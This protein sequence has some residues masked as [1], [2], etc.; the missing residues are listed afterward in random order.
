MRRNGLRSSCSGTLIASSMTKLC[1]RLWFAE[2]A[3]KFMRQLVVEYYPNETGGML[4]GYQAENG[5]IVITSVIGPGPKGIHKPY[6]FVPDAAFQ[7]SQLEARFF[8]SNGHETYLGDWH[9]HPHGTYRLSTTDKKNIGAYCHNRLLR[10]EAPYY[11]DFRRANRAMGARNS[12][13]FRGASKAI[14]YRILFGPSNHC[15]FLMRK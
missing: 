12:P 6:S 4:L 1:R 9:T 8:Q 11:G 15:A 14:L 7:Q 13:I 3:L 5:E 10:N 2:S